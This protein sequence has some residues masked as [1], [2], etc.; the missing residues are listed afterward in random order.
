MSDEKA[1]IYSYDEDTKAI[2]YIDIL[3]FSQLTQQ[4]T[5]EPIKSGGL[6]IWSMVNAIY[7][8]KER[9]RCGRKRDVPVSP[10]CDGLSFKSQSVWPPEGSVNFIL[11]SDC[12]VLYSNSLTHLFETVSLVFGAA[13]VYAVP[14][15]AGIAIG[16]VF[17][18]E[19]SEGSHIVHILYGEAFTR[20]SCL[21]RSIGGTGMRV[22]LDPE[23][24]KLGESI[25]L[26]HRIIPSTSAITPIPAQ[27][28]WWLNCFGEEYEKT[29][30]A[31]ELERQFS[32]WFTEQN[33]KNWFKGDN[34][35]DTKRV[36]QYAVEDLRSF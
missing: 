27:M 25:G 18:S 26:V 28:K 31:N 14:I 12:A 34:M 7:S 30:T 5:N 8:H 4:K 15:R 1:F 2:A 9:M 32:R 23:V 29:K 22:W 11:M 13:T 20:A 17:H 3:G 16:A 21:E 35:E 36:F 33:T 19:L 6:E 24:E 10:H